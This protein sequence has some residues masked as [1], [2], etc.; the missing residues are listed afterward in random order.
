M[1]TLILARHGRTHANVSG[2]L[3][4]RT[5]GVTLDELGEEQAT[6]AA[7]RLEGLPLAAVVSSPMERCRQTAAIL[8]PGAEASVEPG[9]DECDYG[10]WAGRPIKELVKEKLWRT[11]QAHPSGVVFPDGEAMAQ[12][13]RRGVAAVR[14]WDA[15][16]AE[17]HG[18]DAVWLA[19]SHGDVI[20]AILADALGMH[21]DSFQRISVDPASLS[22]VRYTEHR[23]FVLTSNSTSGALA[24]LKPAKRRRGTRKKATSDAVVGGGA[25]P[26]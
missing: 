3:A 1:P 23:P 19:V 25:G 11:V 10:S 13:S 17:E 16:V 20:K 9:L 8:A 18:P 2:V 12:M 24:H 7:A 22:V 5:P 6:A 14:E 4:G 15:R 26:A 21:L